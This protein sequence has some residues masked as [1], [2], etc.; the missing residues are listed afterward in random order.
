VVVVVVGGVVVVLV[1]VVVVVVVVVID[2]HQEGT[3]RHQKERR[4]GACLSEL[5]F[6]RRLAVFLLG[7]MKARQSGSTAAL[8]V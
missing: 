3:V 4:S 8:V 7:R 1:V 6:P 2:R 5:A